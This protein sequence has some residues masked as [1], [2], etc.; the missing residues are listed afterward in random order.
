MLLLALGLLLGGALAAHTPVQAAPGHA[1]GGPKLLL[2]F[3]Y[4]WYGPTSFGNSQMSDAPAAPYISDH[5]DVIERQVTEA[6]GAGIDA[7]VSS[8]QGVGSDTAKNFGKLLTVAARHNFKATIYFET[9]YALQHGDVTSQLG[10]FLAQYQGDPSFL[11]WNDKPVIFFWSPQSLP[12]GVAA[13]GAIRKQLDPGHNQVWSVDATDKAYLDV[14]DTVHFFSGGKWRVSTNVAAVDSQWR[15]ITDSYNAAHGTDR[16]WTADVIP[17]WDESR[18]QPPRPSPKVFPRNGGTA[19]EDNWKAALASNPDMIAI[20]S[21]NEW[22]EDTQIEPSVSYGTQYLDITRQYAAAWKGTA[23]QPA[24]GGACSGGSFFAQTGH[25]ICRQMESYW[26]QYGGLAQFGYP[27]SDPLSEVSATD[28][29]AYTVQY[30]ERARFEL[31][32]EN[33]PPYDV[34]LGLLGRQFHNPDPPAAPLNDGVHQ[35]LPQTGHN[36]GALFYTHWQQHGG[37]FVN[38]YPISEAFTEQGGDGKPYTVQYFERARFELHPENAPPFN[39]LLGVLGRQALAA[40]G[41]H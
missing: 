13:W 9:N 39:V 32:P 35:F 1:G 12:G 33:A 21:Y 24:A 10:A 26:R 18:I 14:F 31:H 23:A 5:P 17:G 28:G 38:G 19:Y 20:T 41:G 15:G 25:A 40:R 2:A 6:Q 7:F 34:M 37:L 3:Y 16:L 8:W 27:I 22:F 4:M 36:V 29:K 30:F 11:H